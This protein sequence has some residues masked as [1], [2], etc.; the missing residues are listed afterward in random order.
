MLAWKA[1]GSKW[2]PWSSRIVSVSIKLGKN[3]NDWHHVFSCY[4]P[5]F[6][7]SREKKEKFYDDLQHSSPRF[8][9]QRCVSYWETLM[10]E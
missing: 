4:A 10:P 8:H 5:T 9:Q 6:A 7:A 1:G 3:E 2:T